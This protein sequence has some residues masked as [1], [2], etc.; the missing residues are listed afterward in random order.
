[1]ENSTRNTDK[2]STTKRK[3]DKT[4]EE[5]WNI[6]GNTSKT[7]N[8]TQPEGTDERRKTKKISRQDKTIQKK[9]NNEKISKLG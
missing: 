4:E 3:N 6:L 5:C 8:T 1:M 7:I 9:Q 2:K